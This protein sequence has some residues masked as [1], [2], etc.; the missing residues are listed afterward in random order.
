MYIMRMC[1][2]EVDKT[3]QTVL[4]QANGFKSVQTVLNQANGFKSVQTVLNQ[5]NGFK[6]VQTVLNRPM[7]LNWFLTHTFL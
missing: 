2:M 1:M 7:V 3:V 4:N 5:A 6:S